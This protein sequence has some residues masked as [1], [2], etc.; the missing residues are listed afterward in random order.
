MSPKRKYLKIFLIIKGDKKKRI[1]GEAAQKNF[2]TFF[3]NSC[4]M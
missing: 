4:K 1:S 2:Q 3:L